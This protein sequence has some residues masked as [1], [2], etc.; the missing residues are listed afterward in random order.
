MIYLPKAVIEQLVRDQRGILGYAIANEVEIG[1]DCRGPEH[2]VYA[3]L[4]LPKLMEG[5]V[6]VK[7]AE[8]FVGDAQ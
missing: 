6:R 5:E 8:K 3:A 1:P 4:L 2:G 7:A